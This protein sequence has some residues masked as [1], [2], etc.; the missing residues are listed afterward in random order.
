[1]FNRE[2]QE[3]ELALVSLLTNYDVDFMELLQN[4]A[5]QSPE[6]LRHIVLGLTLLVH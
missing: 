4:H 6:F 1:M 2:E 5:K 3:M